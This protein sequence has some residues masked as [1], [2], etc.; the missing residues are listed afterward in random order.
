M[1]RKEPATELDARY[2]GE[3]ATA[4][5]WAQARERLAEAEVCWLSTVRPDGRPHVTPLITVW[6]DDAL[7]FTTGPEERKAHNL[8][9]N[10]H[11]VLTTGC[12]ALNE[13]LDLVVEG[14]A[15]RMTDDT[16][17]QTVA[18][19]FQSKYGIDWHFDVRDGAFHHGRGEALVYQV[20]PSTVFGFGK[21]EF[22]QTRY[23]LSASMW[24]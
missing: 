17:L 15:V 21:G 20:A 8:A 13:G 3:D 12:N 11:C 14:A 4:I 9:S 18:D 6:M 22:S 10:P 7:Y 5:P 16:L 19:R 23:R 24:P 1:T 2:S